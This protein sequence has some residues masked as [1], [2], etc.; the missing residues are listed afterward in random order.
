MFIISNIFLIYLQ[1]EQKY[2]KNC[3]TVKNCKLR[4][5]VMASK[6]KKNDSS[7]KEI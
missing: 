4:P 6:I 3:E 2:W 7:K 1:Y 5:F